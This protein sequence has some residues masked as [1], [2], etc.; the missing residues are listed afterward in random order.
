MQP[1]AL[2]PRIKPESLDKLL[3]KVVTAIKLTLSNGDGDISTKIDIL[4]I[5][6]VQYPDSEQP[7]VVVSCS[8]DSTSG[9][10]LRNAN[11]PL[12]D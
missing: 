5:S 7:K 3:M 12:C 4:D 8:V 9:V 11:S 2:S 1:P 10:S 6:V